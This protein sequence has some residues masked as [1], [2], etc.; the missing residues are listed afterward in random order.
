VR[1]ALFLILLLALAAPASAADWVQQTLD[2]QYRLGSREPLVNAPWVGTHNSFNTSTEPPTLSG[3]DN[4][5]VLSLTQQLDIGVRSL[6]LDIHNIN[7]QPLVCHGRGAD[8]GHLG[9]TTERTFAARLEE[10][11]GWLDAHPRQIVLL[12]LEDHLEGAYDAGAQM[13][14]D[15]LGAKLYRPPAG[16]C[17]GMPLQLTRRRIAKAGKQVLAISSCGEGTAWRD[18]IFDDRAREYFEGGADDF[19][20]YPACDYSSRFQRFFEDSTYLTFGVDTVGGA[21]P[22]PG[23]TPEVTAEMSRCGV[24]L[25]GFDKLTAGD[26]RLAALVWSWAKDEPKA[27]RCTLMN[28]AGRFRAAGCRARHRFACGQGGHYAI[29]A[30][31]RPYRRR[32]RR[33]HVAL[34][35]TG[36]EAAKLHDAMVAAGVRTAWLRLTRG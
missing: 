23:L 7:G 30:G 9:C 35:R 2:F 14:D 6:E 11:R 3:E 32:P 16:K 1:R 21:T 31:R 12:Y 22:S 18:L 24:D 28:P 25:T 5:Q 8:E 34:P 10:I 19:E 29:F 36:Y 27:G 13:L 4:N 20:G 17:T 15:V 33:C 26:G